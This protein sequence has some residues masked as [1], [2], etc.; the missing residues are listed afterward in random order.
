MTYD[1]TSFL[2]PAL[3]LHG[4]HPPLL[5]H[6]VRIAQRDVDVLVLVRAERHIPDQQWPMRSAAL[7]GLTVIYHLVQRYAQRIFVAQF[8]HG[9]RI[10]D[11]DY[12][13]TGP[14]DVLGRGVVVR[15]HHRNFLSFMFLGNYM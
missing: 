15:G 4:I 7:H 12:I 3:D 2:G 13:D 9:T 1:G 6:F 10:P 14:I 11:E 5:D 8:D